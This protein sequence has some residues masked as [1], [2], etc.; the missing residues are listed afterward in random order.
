MIVKMVHINPELSIILPCRNEEKAIG[1]CIQ[2]IKEV[3]R[4]NNIN[5]EI[6]VSDSSWD[7]SVEIIKKEGGVRLLKHDKE[8][9]G[10]AYLR[11]F[12][13]VKGKYVFM[14]D[15]DGTYDF[16]EIP[17]Y[18]KHLREG[19]DLVMGDRFKKQIEDGAMP[20]LH[21]YV[22]NPILSGILRL[23]FGTTVG[24]SHCGMRAISKQALDSLNLKTTG[25]EFASEMIIK[26]VK[27]KLSIKEIP[28]NYHARIGDSKLRTFRDGWRHLR[29]MLLYSP[30]FLFF[31]PGLILFLLGLI[32]VMALFFNNPEVLGVVL[33]VH[34]MIL[35]ALCIMV[36][37][38]LIMF[39]LF[40]K[41]YAVTHLGEGGRF[42]SKIL[43]YM[44]IEKAGVFSLF[45]IVLGSVIYIIILL[46]WVNS[47]FG[48]LDEIK[49][50][51]IALT[52]IVIGIQTLSSAFMLS[53]LGIK[54]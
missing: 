3:L 40:A 21:R 41:T 10:T 53:V 25:M 47:G 4:D 49:N 28:I 33:Y 24:D 17:N 38:Q 46:K 16:N 8:G 35:G 19:Y 22:G 44:T 11:A 7:N 52:L 23:F 20:F 37:Y 45:L 36:G 26:A 29:F 12:R 6:I 2:K 50:S 1:F 14:A 32:T 51:I 43:K 31:L 18:L 15:A 48:A 42:I 27:N 5:A 13:H 34:P 30:L 54:G 39:S 9:Y